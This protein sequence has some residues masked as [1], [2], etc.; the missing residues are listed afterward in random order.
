MK[1]LNEINKIVEK[2]VNLNI[3]SGIQPSEVADAIFLEQYQDISLS[4]TSSSVIMV[5]KFIEFDDISTEESVHKMRYVYDLNKNLQKIEQSVNGG[6]FKVQW[7]LQNENEKL[8]KQFKRNISSLDN[9]IDVEK[10]VQTLPIEL[11][12]VVTSHLKLVA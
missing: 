6:R 1:L 2:I 12:N 7:S 11:R 10:I 8:I 3:F 4:K 5:V 9:C